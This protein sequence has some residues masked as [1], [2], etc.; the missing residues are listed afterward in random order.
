MNLDGSMLREVSPVEGYHFAV[1]PE[2][3]EI[4]YQAGMGGVAIDLQGN[5][6]RPMPRG[7]YRSW[8][9]DGS[10]LTYTWG[11]DLFVCNADGSGERLLPTPGFETDPSWSPDSQT[12]IFTSRVGGV[13][14]LYTIDLTTDTVV[15]KTFD[16]VWRRYP[17]YSPDGSQVVTTVRRADGTLFLEFADDPGAGAP[18]QNH[19]VLTPG[20]GDVLWGDWAP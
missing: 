5:V 12:I 1:N 20:G 8:S 11:T 10:Q 3:T 13:G 19:R 17:R 14:G 15:Q 7:A 4:V 16:G 6:L 18:L 9:P 2:G